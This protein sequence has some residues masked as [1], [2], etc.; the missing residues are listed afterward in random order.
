MPNLP[1]LSEHAN[2]QQF[3]QTTYNHTKGNSVD[4]RH[5]M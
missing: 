4:F 2:Y 5:T 3:K 1:Q